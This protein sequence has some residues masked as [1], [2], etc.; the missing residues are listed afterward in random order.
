M[1]TTS[2]SGALCSCIVAHSCSVECSVVSLR[3]LPRPPLRAYLLDGHFF[4]AAALAS[5]LTKLTLRYLQMTSEPHSKNVRGYQAT[6]NLLLLTRVCV[7][8]CVCY[9]LQAFCAETM[10]ILASVLHLGRSGIPKK[11]LSLYTS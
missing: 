5:T 1:A 9:F 10:L 4:I 6:Q 3:L 7:C 8:V 2:K 11:V